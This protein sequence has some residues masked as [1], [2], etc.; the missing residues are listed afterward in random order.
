MSDE[1]K[2]P[3]DEDASAEQEGVTEETQAEEPSADTPDS[4]AES[5]ETP[6]QAELSDDPS[7]LGHEDK[8]AA[9]DDGVEDPEVAALHEDAAN[10]PSTGSPDVSGD[11]SGDGGG[12]PPV[13]ADMAGD[14]DDDGDEGEDEDEDE[15]DGEEGSM[16]FTEHLQELR[17]R[18]TRCFI[19]L[20]VGFLACYGFSKD[21]FDI[22][23][24]PLVTV[25]PPG[26]H[27]IFTALPE[28]FFTYIK[29]AL[30][31]GFFLTSP[32][33][34][35]QLWLFI[36]PGLYKE[37]RKYLIPIGFFSA[38]FFVVG[39][40]FGYFVVFPFAF[41]FFMGFTTEFI[42]PF[43]KLNEYLG[44]SLKLLFAFGVI[45][46]LPLVIFFLARLGLVTSTMLRKVRKFAF[47]GCFVISAVLTPP[48][49]VSQLLMAGPLMLLYEISIYVAQL[50][51]RREKRH[52]KDEDE[53]E[54]EEENPE[55][56]AEEESA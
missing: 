9:S 5:G 37:E 53:E 36:S 41:K 6:V 23:M 16:S 40:S 1:T 44:F 52:M 24:R 25:F 47:L 48:D 34:F 7:A 4:D 21:L 13:P 20:V 2:K 39:A 35:Y 29:V 14:F 15:E 43:P 8:E 55:E 28:A 11:G 50:F 45:F 42:K 27:L 18:L 38:L 49:V 33:I 17:Q 22:L 56:S 51:G 19:A 46:E 10:D 12:E 30:V 32:Y 3:L 31:A 54:T 26:S